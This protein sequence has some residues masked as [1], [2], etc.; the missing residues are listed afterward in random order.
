MKFIYNDLGQRKK[1]EIVEVT[2][3]GAANVRLMNSSNYSSYK[4]GRDHRYVGGLAKQT[5]VR[6]SIPNSG[7]W[8]VT[9]D[10][11]GLV[12]SVKAS[13]R[14]LPNP[15]PDLKEVPLSSIPSLVQDNT[16]PSAISES[17]EHDVFYF[18][19]IRR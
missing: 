14:T 3:S 8:Y 1:G 16:P 2:L 4:N 5:P 19:C 10:M 9:V 7:R 17:K 6:L 12:G 13:F 11:Q 15:L 18:T